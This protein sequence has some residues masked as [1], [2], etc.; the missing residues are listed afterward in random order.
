MKN[1][2]AECSLW[3]NIWIPIENA[4]KTFKE[5]NQTKFDKI[6]AV[7]INSIT[8]RYVHFFL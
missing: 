4:T 6:A 7:E 8:N 5:M 1:E 2:A 3:C